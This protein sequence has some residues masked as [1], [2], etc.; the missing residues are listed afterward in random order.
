[1]SVQF[2]NKLIQKENLNSDEA[3]A[4]MRSIVTGEA[5]EIC[6]AAIL[7]TLASKGETGT[8]MASF[9]RV[10][11]EVATPWPSGSL[12]YPILCDTCGTGGDGASTLNISTLSAIVL[13][14]LDIPVAKHGNRAVSSQS[15]SADLL[16]ALGIKLEYTHQK[17]RQCLE[18][19]GITFLFAPNWHPAMKYAIPVRKA[20]GVRTVFNLLGPI[21]NPAPVTH[22]LVGVF[23]KS[24][25][26]VIAEALRELGK[27]AYIVFSSDGLD[28]VSWSAPTH[29]IRVGEGKIQES[30][31]IEPGDFG[32]PLHKKEDLQISGPNEALH[33]GLRFL[34]GKANDAENHAVAMNA[35][36]LHSLVCSSNLKESAQACL[37]AIKNGC[38]LS[39][40]EKWRSFV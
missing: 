8:E 26:E 9:A 38:G 6:T 33:R 21:T 29:F 10:M 23:Q 3:E 30:G 11:R 15:G 37:E 35:A 2:L 31:E 27:K 12:S 28:E 5:G 39:I 17:V 24:F 18:K 1:M 4:L 13:A 22:Q 40:L 7:S 32:F 16:E 36:F 19:I 14:S 20:L 25:Q 34:E